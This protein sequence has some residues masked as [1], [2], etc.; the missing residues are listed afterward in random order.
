MNYIF[1]IYIK[2]RSG[3]HEH[4]AGSY[5]YIYSSHP[6]QQKVASETLVKWFD[7][8]DVE[9]ISVTFGHEEFVG[10]EH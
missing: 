1:Q 7:D 3:Q 10:Y 8:D 4:P 9:K 6:D 5:S 2:L